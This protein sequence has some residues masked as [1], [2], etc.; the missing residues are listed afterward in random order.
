M[1][2]PASRFS[3][4]RAFTLVELLAVIAII[5]VLAGILFSVLGKIR[6]SA[7]LATCTSNLR[8]VHQAL[9]LYANERRGELLPAW[10]SSGTFPAGETNDWRAN[11]GRGGYL[12]RNDRA[13]ADGAV[14]SETNWNQNQF[15]VFTCPGFIRAHQPANSEIATMAMNTD[16][17]SRVGTRRV[18]IAEFAQPAKLLLLSD[19]STVE[20]ANS[21]VNSGLQAHTA[22]RPDGNAHG[23]LVNICYLDG[24]VATMQIGDLPLGSAGLT[25]EGTPIWTLWRGR[26]L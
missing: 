26:N 10:Q 25:T 2:T 1:R 18:R 21:S 9:M 8:T 11:L 6:A 24:H 19:G 5:G 15:T 7:A 16:A 13:R 20:L 14:S 3:R 4:H 17:T 22:Y 12:T 23:G